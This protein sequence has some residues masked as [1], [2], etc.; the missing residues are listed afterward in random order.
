MTLKTAS[1]AREQQVV[2]S[3]NYTEDWFMRHPEGVVLVS[4]VL[5]LIYV[6]N[7]HHVLFVDQLVGVGEVDGIT[8]LLKGSQDICCYS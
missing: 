6:I 3:I 4:F 8:L 1:A 7:F 5:T 2:D